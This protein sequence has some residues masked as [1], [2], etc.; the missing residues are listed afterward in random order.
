[1][2]DLNWC[3]DVVRQMSSIGIC[4]FI[5]SHL[6]DKD[7]KAYKCLKLKEIGLFLK[8]TNS[9]STS[10]QVSSCFFALFFSHE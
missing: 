10:K 3:C 7:Y 6:S 4:I 8:D 2:M 1:M 9:E 5:P